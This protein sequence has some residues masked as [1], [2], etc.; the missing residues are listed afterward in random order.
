MRDSRE[1]LLA[2]RPLHLHVPSA[3]PDLLCLQLP[4]LFEAQSAPGQ[5]VQQSLCTS[6]ACVRC[7]TALSCTLVLIVR[8]ADASASLI[9]T[10]PD[11]STAGWT[12]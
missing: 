12:S 8:G 5:S 2:V 3:G 4:V 7:Y 9:R 10:K 6:M 1:S 11:Q